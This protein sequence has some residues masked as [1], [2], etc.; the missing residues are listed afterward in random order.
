MPNL[1]TFTHMGNPILKQVAEPIDLDHIQSYRTLI[2]DMMF[3]L[4]QQDKRLG[5]AAPQV[6]VSKRIFIFRLPDKIHPRYGSET[7]TPLPL[8]ALINPELAPLSDEEVI[9]WEACISV[10]GLVGKVPRYKTIT[11][12][13]YDIDGQ[14]HTRTAEGFHARVV[15]HEMDHLNGIL[16]P[17]RMTDLST[18]SF[19][20]EMIKFA[21][22]GTEAQCK[23][24]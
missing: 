19:E 5:L 23:T 10:P 22:S 20:E 4:E 18:F 12:S 15:Q 7:V 8:H 21:E 9:G 1:L 17:E 16:F 6:G 3:T 24:A 13:Y 11:Y 2:E 14:K